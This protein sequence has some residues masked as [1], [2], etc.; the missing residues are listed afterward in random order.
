MTCSDRSVGLARPRA[1][2]GR[3]HRRQQPLDSALPLAWAGVPS[4][5][6]LAHVPARPR[7]SSVG[8]RSVH[9]ADAHVQDPVRAGFSNPRRRELAP[10]DPGD[11]LATGAAPSAARSRRRLWSRLPPASQTGRDRRQRQAHSITAC[12][13]YRG[14]CQ[15]DAPARVLGPRRGPRRAAPGVR[16]D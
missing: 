11:A 16:A 4:Q 6:D 9:R 8:G 7:S 12:E 10:A 14:A 2:A 1:S 3:G 15:R 13:C 5:P